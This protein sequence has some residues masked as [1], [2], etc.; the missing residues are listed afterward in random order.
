MTK[1][2]TLSLLF[3]YLFLYSLLGYSAF[4]AVQDRLEAS[5]AVLGGSVALFSLQKYE[6]ESDQDL[7]EIVETL[8]GQLMESRHEVEYYK[9]KLIEGDL[10]QEYQDVVNDNALEIKQ[11]TLEKEGFAT[12][13]TQEETANRSKEQK[14][15]VLESENS[16]LKEQIS[17][18]E[19]E[20]ILT[21]KRPML[22]GDKISLDKQLGLNGTVESKNSSET[23][24]NGVVS[25]N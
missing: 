2:L 18:M 6:N 5:G 24:Q 20:R 13:V 8:Q 19:K 25:V 4:L 12:A 3:R 10:R 11:L 14:I 16:R 1:H 22:K 15:S 23:P 17:K 21:M 9:Y 7:E